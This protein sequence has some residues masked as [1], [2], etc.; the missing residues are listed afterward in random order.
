MVIGDPAA[1]LL[2]LVQAP[3]DPAPDTATPAEQRA[4][5]L[6]R[7]RFGLALPPPFAG[8]PGDEPVRVAAAVDGAAIAAVKWRTFG[9]SYRGGVLPD[10]FLDRREVVPPASFWT[11]RAMVPPSRLHRLLV[12]GRPGTVF[13]Y[14]DLGPV[15]PDD[16]EPGAADA[17][18]V[19]ELYVDP[20]AQGAGGGSRLLDAAE[21]WFADRGLARV[22]LTTLATNL[23]AQAFYA[24]RG[25]APTGR[26]THV[27]L[28]T[29]AFD[30]V[31]FASDGPA[32]SDRP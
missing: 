28:G 27:D 21:A 1:E 22:E 2:A 13:G 16:R 15:H 19:Y 9:T 10:A 6:V 26:V 8:R 14:A 5:A 32:R 23:R 11:G 18:E 29:V 17:G 24:A 4:A 25:W 12:W 7:R 30:E 31:R 20:S 3:G